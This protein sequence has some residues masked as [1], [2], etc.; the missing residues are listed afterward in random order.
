MTYQYES[1]ASH[2]FFPNTEPRHE[3]CQK[4][5]TTGFLGQKLYIPK[6]HKLRLFLLTK[7]QRKSINI[8]NLSNFVVRIPFSVKNFN[9]F[10]VKSLLLCANLVLLRKLC[11][12]S[13][14]F[15][16]KIYTD[17]KNFTQPPVATV[18]T[19]LNSFLL[20]TF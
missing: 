6:V 3:I 4:F 11:K 15:L 17:G 12:K 5:Y 20:A 14:C 13:R 9:G 2:L 16:E 8:N 7:K 1:D 10:N 18:A 19:N